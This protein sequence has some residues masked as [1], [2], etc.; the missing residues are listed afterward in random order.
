M[1]RLLL[2]ALVGPPL[3]VGPAAP[4]S[5][6]EPEAEAIQAAAAETLA[7]RYPERAD[8]LKVRVRRVRGDVDPDG[9][10]RLRFSEGEGSPTGVT[11]ASIHSKDAEGNWTEDGWALLHVARF[12]SVATIRGRVKGGETI[13]TDEL[14]IAWIETSDV[15]GEPLRAGEARDRAR[16]GRLVADRYLQSGRVLRTRDVRR[17]NT[18]DAGGAV[19]VRYRR[20]GIVFRV[21]C[22]ARE[23]G[24]IEEIIRVHCGELETMYRVRITSETT[25]E[26]V[27]TL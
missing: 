26:W 25:A 22:T 20:G 9:S 14:E 18:V 12:D 21:S 11:R 10:M 24:V 15:R 13:P 2:F 17:P 23:A 27:E 4:C 8:R 19:R 16:R 5:A 6:Q 3:A 7:G 1:W